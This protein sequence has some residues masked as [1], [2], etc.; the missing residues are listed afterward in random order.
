M[1]PSRRTLW[2]WYVAAMAVLT[3]CYLAVPPLKGY[4]VVIN[5][6]GLTSPV[7]IGVAIWLHKPKARLAWSLLLLGQLLYFAGDFY[8]YSYPDLLGGNVGFP[9]LGD[10]IYLSVYPALVGG[11]LLLV[12]RRNPASD[13]AASIDSVILTVGFALL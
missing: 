13:R 8:T 7:A 11:L 2:L 4:A 5:I 1:R 10:A 3:V 9:S 12:R 6:I